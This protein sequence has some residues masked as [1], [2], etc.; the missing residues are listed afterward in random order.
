[1]EIA[2]NKSIIGTF[3]IIVALSLILSFVLHDI[4][5]HDHH[6]EANSTTSSIQAALHTNDKKWWYLMLLAF[7]FVA[8]DLLRK[9]RLR[10]YLRSG[11]LTHFYYWRIDLSKLFNPILQ[12]LRRGILNPKLC[13]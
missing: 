11:A 8:V 12:A 1:M 5:P 2:F 10:T 7:V 9:W 4:I 3:L 6:H 13:D